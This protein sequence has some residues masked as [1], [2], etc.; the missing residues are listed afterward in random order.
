MSGK[1]YLAGGG[2]GDPGLLTLR[3]AELISVVDVVVIDALVSEPIRRMIPPSTRV[4]Y[5]GKRAGQHSLSQEAINDLLLEL[6]RAGQ[7]VLRLKGGD[8]F[9]FGRG[10]EEAERLRAEGIEF[11]IVPGITAGIA[12]PAYAGIPV[13]HRSRA[14]S[15]TFVT[16]HESDET[17]GVEWNALA[18]AGGT[19]VFYMGLGRLGTICAKLRDAGLRATT[20][21]AV[22]S[23]ATTPL[24]RTVTGTLE[25][26]EEAVLAAELPAPALIVVGEVVGLAE[27]ISW[28]ETRPL[29]GRTVVVTRARAQASDLARLL[30][31]R[32]ARVL[33]FPMIAIEEPEDWRSLDDLIA[34][35]DTS[36]W[37]IF[38]SRNGVSYFFERMMHLGR[39]ARALAGRK[40]AAV[41]EVTADALRERGIRP[42]LV[43]E[44]YQSTA[45]LP[46]LPDDLQGSQIAIV[47]AEEGNDA[48]IR[49][50][51]A[52]GAGVTL[53]VAY[54]TVGSSEG[55]DELREMIAKGEIDV[56][57]F[58]S[59]S[60]VAQFSRQVPTADSVPE[61]TP[62]PRFVS[63][64]PV[65]SEAMR[66][67]G[68]AV[69]AE[70]D[71]ATIVALARSVE[72][73]LP[74]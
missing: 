53:G 74:R 52:R 62:R 42:D 30:Q 50:L 22:I 66:S 14:T 59:G 6:A 9:V 37:L 17:S 55:S 70:A 72:Q 2:P 39:D 25:T 69:D 18:S 33:E 24:Q 13:T 3:V 68:I 15:V 5:A 27:S 16:G 36:D 61:G 31:E 20:P 64:G 23:K 54:R 63:I 47:R 34:G 41:G 10:G 38:S 44:K 26:I 67:H 51:E 35:L 49:E 28:F 7:T 1:V 56:V 19:I 73:A 11:E 40:I 12:G 4:V 60:T 29:F 32:G 46:H 8:P 45:L 21:A 65:T 43:P 48:F 71:E 57:T 58:T